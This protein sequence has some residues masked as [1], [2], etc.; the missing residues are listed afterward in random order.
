M[1]FAYLKRNCA[2]TACLHHHRVQTTRSTV[3]GVFAAEK[4]LAVSTALVE[5]SMV[6]IFEGT[7]ERHPTASLTD[8]CPAAL[9]LPVHHQ[10]V[11]FAGHD[12]SPMATCDTADESPACSRLVSPV[13]VAHE[14][15]GGNDAAASVSTMQPPLSARSRSLTA[16]AA[17]AKQRRTSLKAVKSVGESAP[18]SD[19]S[20]AAV[21]RRSQPLRESKRSSAASLSAAA[22][23]D[24]GTSGDDEEDV[25]EVNAPVDFVAG[26]YCNSSCFCVRSLFRF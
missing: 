3:A 14:D 16:K 23:G 17:P 1:L 7:M 6:R 25:D 11:P 4:S 10:V 24:D 5:S 19:N 2:Q 9:K 21:I 8:S 18:I 20:N 22:A 26:A 12:D 13:A 15:S